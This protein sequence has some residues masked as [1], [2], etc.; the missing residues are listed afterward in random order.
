MALHIVEV[1]HHCWPD[2]PAVAVALAPFSLSTDRLVAEL[3]SCV[4]TPAAYQQGG[5]QQYLAD[6]IKRHLQN[7]LTSSYG[8]SLA[9]DRYSPKLN[10]S[11]DLALARD[12]SGKR[13]F[14][15]VEFR[16][17]VE[18]DLVKFQIGENRGTLAAAV[19]I[20]AIDRTNI[21][22]AYSTMPEY[23]KFER[24]IQEL[25]PSYPLV[26]LGIRVSNNAA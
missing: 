5:L 22:R 20:L 15:E 25:R 23:D 12:S 3:R 7:T 4:H 2:E 9:S 13:I 17:N 21:N 6:T 16:P 26:L 18:K 14:F 19:L 10:E 1:R 24:I 8:L 11:A